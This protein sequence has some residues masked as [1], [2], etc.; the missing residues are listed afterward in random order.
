MKAGFW[1]NGWGTHEEHGEQN[2]CPN[3]ETGEVGVRIM[4]LLSFMSSL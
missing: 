2:L 1:A 4:T 3:V